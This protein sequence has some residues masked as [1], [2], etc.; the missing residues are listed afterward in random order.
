[1]KEEVEDYI[2]FCE[3]C[4]TKK[5]AREKTRLPMMITTRATEVFEIVEI[6]VVGP[7]RE[8]VCGHKYILT[9][10]DN[11]SKYACAMPLVST[12]A[13]MIATVFAEYFICRFGALKSL[14][15]IWE[16]TFSLRLC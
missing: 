6:D 11:L 10:G 4:Q 1:M 14:K 2:K 7:L 13:A 12:D 15:R 5:L 8:S 3:G 9:V 16:P